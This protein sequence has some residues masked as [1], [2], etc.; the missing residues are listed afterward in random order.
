MLHYEW[1]G[2]RDPEAPVVVMSAGLGGAGAYWH[3]QVEA[4]GARFRVLL[5][6]Q[7][8]TGQSAAVLPEG[9]SVENMAEELIELAES[10][11][12]ERFDFVGHAF[13]GL[14][15]LWL[16]R[17]RPALVRRL[18]VAGGWVSLDSHSRRCFDARI[19]LLTKVGARAYLAAQ[20][21][22]LFP[23]DWLSANAERVD[24]EQASQLAHFPGA[25][26][27]LK[28]IEA[29]AGFDAR[30]WIAEIET[31]TLVITARDDVLVPWT[32]SRRLAE[33]MPQGRFECLD[34]GGHACS[35][36]ASDEFDRRLVE[37]LQS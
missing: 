18:V 1:L 6:D 8:G 11:G 33:L 31:P 28:R 22:F 4:L 25:G 3:P 12:L 15:G 17:K 20:P 26:N 10:L 16:A 7:L 19:A 27:V 14:V 5:Y 37:F 21:I 34:Y 24:R 9:Y 32:A 23:A 30:G 35:V 13:G 36:T 29:L 2:S